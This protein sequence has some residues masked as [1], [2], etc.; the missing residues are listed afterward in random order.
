MDATGRDKYGHLP[1]D[2]I[3][4]Q[5][6]QPIVLALRVAIVDLYVPAIDMTGFVQASLKRGVGRRRGP[7]VQEPDHRHRRLLRARRERP[8]YRRAATL[9]LP[10]GDQARVRDFWCFGERSGRSS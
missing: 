2:E 3:G 1:A 10:P 8:R 4:R 7:A 6:R 5:R 9:K